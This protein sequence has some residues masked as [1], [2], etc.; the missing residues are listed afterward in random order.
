MLPPRSRSRKNA[1]TA[2]TS[3]EAP[4]ATALSC[5]GMNDGPPRSCLLYAVPTPARRDG[6][7]ADESGGPGAG[8]GAGAD[9]GALRRGKLPREGRSPADMARGSEVGQEGQPAGPRLVCR[10]IRRE[11]EGGEGAGGACPTQ[12]RR[13]RRW[14]AG[15]LRGTHVVPASDD[16]RT[17]RQPSPGGRQ[18][19]GRQAT[20]TQAAHAVSQHGLQLRAAAPLQQLAGD[21]D[22]VAP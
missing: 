14:V 19:L 17:Q 22:A 18:R 20:S 5:T 7:S 4:I 15:Q 10:R 21:G 12:R 6:L 13:Q 9:R 11:P 8:T 16:R 1:L 2:T 3:T